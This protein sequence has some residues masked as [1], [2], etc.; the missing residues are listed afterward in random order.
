MGHDEG[1]REPPRYQ[2]FPAGQ[3][4]A[5]RGDAGCS[6]PPPNIIL[7]LLIIIIIIVIRIIIIIIIE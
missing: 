2:C 4:P 1:G 5:S 6:A 3:R 7:F